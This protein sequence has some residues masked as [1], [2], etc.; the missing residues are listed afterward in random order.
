M[1]AVLRLLPPR[2]HDYKRF[3]TPSELVR[4]ARQA[5]LS[6][7][8]MTGLHYNPLTRRYWLSADTSVNYMIACRKPA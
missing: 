4:F 1:L 5:A 8:A 6:L 7:D 2:T 3:I